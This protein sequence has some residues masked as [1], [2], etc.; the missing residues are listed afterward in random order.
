MPLFLDQFDNA[1]RVAETGYGVRLN[2]FTVSEAELL[3]TIDKV[4]NDKIL[5]ERCRKAG[6]RIR[7]AN[8]RERVADLVEKVAEEHL[9]FNQWK[10]LISD[11]E[12]LDSAI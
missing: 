2:P 8:N 6:E 1:T 3:S 11:H 12:K 5:I 10:K 9:W 4:L 7:S